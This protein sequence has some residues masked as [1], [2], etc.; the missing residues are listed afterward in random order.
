MATNKAKFVYVSYIGSTPEKVFNALMDPELTKQYWGLHRNVSDWKVGSR[1]EHQD[2]EDAKKVAVVGKV[3]EFEPPRRLVLSWGS[4]A[5]EAQPEK[6]SRVTFLVEPFADAVRLTVTHD[7]LEP[8]S[9]MYRGISAGWPAILSSMKTLLESGKP[10][11]M[12][13]RRWGGQQG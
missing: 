8:E 12:T 1:W 6:H 7:E 2:Y 5:D 11:M 3:L 10:M 13:T 9:P 4:P